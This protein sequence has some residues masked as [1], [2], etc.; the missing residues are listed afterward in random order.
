[1]MDIQDGHAAQID[2]VLDAAR[3]RIAP[4]VDPSQLS[5]VAP[6]ALIVDIRPLE[7][8][9]RDGE[10][11]D[12][13]QIDRNVLEWRLDPTSSNRSSKCKPGQTVVLVVLTK[14]GTLAARGVP[15]ALEH[16]EEM[17]KAGHEGMTMEESDQPTNYAWGESLPV[18][19]DGRPELHS[20]DPTAP[21]T[22]KVG[23]TA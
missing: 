16:L 5:A 17:V 6:R 18:E 10:L 2:R 21:E 8:R 20:V 15:N 11:P 23:G 19:G 3:R 12:A 22:T 4:R 13:I 1:M 7:Q 14:E 9:L